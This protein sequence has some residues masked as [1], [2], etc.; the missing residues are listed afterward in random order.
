M[1]PTNSLSDARTAELHQRIRRLRRWI[2]LLLGFFLIV[3]LPAALLW[4]RGGSSFIDY[5]ERWRSPVILL[6]LLAGVC[7]VLAAFLALRV[8]RLSDQLPRGS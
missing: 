7:A 3:G 1:R 4:G 6:G 8:S 2:G 5:P